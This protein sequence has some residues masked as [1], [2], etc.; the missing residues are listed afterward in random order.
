M[1]SP[2]VPN[3]PSDLLEVDWELLGAPDSVIHNLYHWYPQVGRREVAGVLVGCLSDPG[4]YVLDPFCGTGTVMAEAWRQ[5]RHPVGGDINPVASLVANARLINIDRMQWDH[6]VS[7]LRRRVTE[8]LLIDGFMAAAED[9]EIPNYENIR[10]WYHENTLIELAA[11]W[12]SIRE[13]PH[14]YTLTAEA[15]FSAILRAVSSRRGPANRI[16]DNVPSANSRISHSYRAILF[17]TK[18]L[19]PELKYSC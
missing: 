5:E 15:S 7:S 9:L 17:S 13:T 10:Q 19:S 3:L 11:I 8:Y 18:C 12:R 4:G 6:Y 2:V 14:P 1:G 16:A